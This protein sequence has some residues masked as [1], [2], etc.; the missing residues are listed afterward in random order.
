[1][2]LRRSIG[3]D[4][5]EQ[6]LLLVDADQQ[7]RGD[8]VGELAR[9][10]DADGGDHRVVVQVVRQLH[11]L[12]EQRHDAAHRRFRRR[13]S[14]SLLLRQHLDDD[15]VEALVFLPLD[16]AGALDALDQHLDVAVG[17]LQALDDVGDAAHRV[18]V[19]GPRV[20]DRRVVLRGEEDP[21]VLQQRVL[22]RARRATAVR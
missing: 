7:V 16:G 13:R 21:L 18:D 20:V 17:Q 6:V 22:E 9:V 2:R 10:V 14:A 4:D 11:V 3:R 12:L 5:L 15:A 19:F 8:R 1:M